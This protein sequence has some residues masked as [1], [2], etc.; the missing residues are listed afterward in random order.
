MSRHHSLSRKEY[1]PGSLKI[2]I[3]PCGF[4]T[5]DALAIRDFLEDPP[6]LAIKAVSERVSSDVTKV[7]SFPDFPDASPL[8]KSYRQNP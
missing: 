1:F 3:R 4:L 7:L 6:V 5:P 2:K 8:L